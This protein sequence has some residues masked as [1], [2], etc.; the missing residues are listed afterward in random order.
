LQ[1]TVKAKQYYLGFVSNEGRWFLFTPA[2]QDFH[3]I[4][5]VDDGSMPFAGSQDIRSAG[6]DH[7]RFK[8]KIQRSIGEALEN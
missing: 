1:F 2:A 8:I 7:R 6:G 4:P 3:R 5:V